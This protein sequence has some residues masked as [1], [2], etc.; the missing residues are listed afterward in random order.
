MLAAVKKWYP[1]ETSPP[2]TQYYEDLALGLSNESDTLTRLAKDA[3]APNIIRSSAILASDQNRESLEAALDLVESS[4]P[5]LKGCRD[6][7][8]DWPIGFLPRPSCQNASCHSAITV[9]THHVRCDWRRH[10]SPCPFRPTS[11]TI[12][13]RRRSAPPIRIR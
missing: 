6:P 5:Q 13:P 3:T 8:S 7:A 10:N 11:E 9:L 1:A 4:E 12:S 2:K